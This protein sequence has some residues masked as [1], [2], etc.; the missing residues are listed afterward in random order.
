M[1]VEFDIAFFAPNRGETRA[2]LQGLGPRT[3]SPADIRH[4]PA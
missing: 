3:E 1:I 4:H 2:F